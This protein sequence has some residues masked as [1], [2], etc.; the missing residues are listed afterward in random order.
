MQSKSK[1]PIERFLNLFTEVR[2]GEGPN[3]LL[4]ALN[5]FLI[6]TSYYIMKPVR[7]A[8]I[9]S[10]GFGE[11][12]G[13]V[14]KSLTAAGQVILLIGAIP[15]YAK[16]ASRVP[17]RRLINIVTIF[18]ASCLALFYILALSRVPLG[19][20]FYLWIGIFNLMLPAQLW[21]F[22]NDLYTPEA[23]KRIFVIIG[24]GASLGAVL[25]GII[26]RILIAPLGIYQLLLLAGG[27]LLSSLIITNI[28]DSRERSQSTTK[29]QKTPDEPFSKKGAFQLVLKNK[30]LLMVAFLIFFLN[31]VN[32]T[33]E[34]ILGQTVEN[35]AKREVQTSQV[36][37]E[38]ANHALEK[39][40]SEEPDNEALA[41]AVTFDQLSTTDLARATG[42]ADE[43]K[44]DWVKEYIDGFYS[45][46]YTGVNILGLILQLFIVSRVLKYAG[47][48]IALFI[49]PL[50]ALTGYFFIIFFPVLT[51]IR[52]AKT[53]EN[54]TDYSLQNTVRHI[55]FLPTTR[56]EKYK[57]KQAIDTFFWRA[58]DLLSAALVLLGTTLLAFQTKHFALFNVGLIIIWLILAFRI[59][60]ENK[61]LIPTQEGDAPINQ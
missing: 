41:V 17:R 3:A 59:G 28:I 47:I 21:A 7:E 40:K 60:K 29:K 54:G 51:I 50:I 1:S 19:V 15:L 10:G 55:L 45:I 31:W 57:A 6:F 58:G 36:Q 9:L 27:L 42:H 52:L 11:L 37:E 12:S 5:I 44:S 35:T 53:A 48:R 22:S 43:Y 14:V 4:L 61:K 46:F 49:L 26:N 30:Y 18:F 2:A 23:G 20:I 16:I 25:G 33:G 38:A 39:L 8:L 32:T 24:F 34:Y 56:E 13:A